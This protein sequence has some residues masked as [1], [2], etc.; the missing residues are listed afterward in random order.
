MTSESVAAQLDGVGRLGHVVFDGAHAPVE[1]DEAAG[2]R[3]TGLD[4]T[5]A[6]GRLNGPGEISTLK[7][8]LTVTEA[9]GGTPR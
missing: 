4:A 5:V 1:L 7:G 8:D 9:A 3:L 6:V 2:V